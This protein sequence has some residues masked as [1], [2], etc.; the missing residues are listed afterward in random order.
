M[1]EF[2]AFLAPEGRIVP[3]VLPPQLTAAE[4]SQGATLAQ[5]TRAFE[6]N[7]ILALLAKNGSHL[8]GKKKTA[9]ELGISLAS[10]YN[11]LAAPTF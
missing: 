2:S 5:R 9:A 8:A 7:E 11:K 3:G 1:L 10:L 4:Q 6:R